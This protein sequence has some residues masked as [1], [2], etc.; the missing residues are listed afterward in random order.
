MRRLLELP[1]E[2]LGDLLERVVEG[3]AGPAGADDHGLDRE[4]R[5]L[6]PPQGKVGADPR[7]Q[8]DEHQEDDEGAMADGPRGQV[9]AHDVTPS[10]RTF[11]PGRSAWTPAVTTTSPA[12]M[13]WETVTLAGS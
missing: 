7:D 2:A 9:E 13:P 3:R 12:S 10:R 6:G 11:C 5:V 8:D 1:L 4:R